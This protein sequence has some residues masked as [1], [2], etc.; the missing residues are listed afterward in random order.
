MHH[1]GEIVSS[2]LHGVI[3]R[4]TTFGARDEVPWVSH[5]EGKHSSASAK[6]GTTHARYESERGH[7]HDASKPRVVALRVSTRVPTRYALAFD[8]G[9]L[10]VLTNGAVTLDAAHKRDPISDAQWDPLSDGYLL[11]GFS[12]GTLHMYDVESKAQ[13]QTFDKQPGLTMIAWMPGVPGDFVT[14][15]DKA[16]SFAAPPLPRR[17]CHARR[18]RRLSPPPPLA[19]RL[20]SDRRLVGPLCTGRPARVEC[21]SPCPDGYHQG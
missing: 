2:S 20:A 3:T 4:S 7:A 9:L 8:S 19:P 18:P 5:A 16:V 21:V 14:A 15:S 12:S 11:V 6:S 1:T 13:L 10:L 17:P